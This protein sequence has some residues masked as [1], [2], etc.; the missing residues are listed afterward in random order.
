MFMI[1]I[2]S[3]VSNVLI[4]CLLLDTWGLFFMAGLLPW[5]RPRTHARVCD[6][7]REK[8]RWILVVFPWLML[9]LGLEAPMKKMYRCNVQRY[10]MCWA[11]FILCF[12]G[13]AT[14]GALTV[15]T[16]VPQWCVLL[17]MWALLLNELARREDDK[18]DRGD[19]DHPDRQPPDGPTPTGDATERW[20]ISRQRQLILVGSSFRFL[21][22]SSGTVVQSPHRAFHST[23]NATI[24]CGTVSQ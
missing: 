12:L 22:S 20:L 2:A 24:V 14:W 11:L 18:G 6:F 21:H 8:R 3:I 9:L 7:L 15:N 13:L 5:L 10:W 1:H 4:D 17:Y 23:L 16:D 19:D